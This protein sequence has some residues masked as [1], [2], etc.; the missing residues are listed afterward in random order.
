MDR[1]RRWL[2]ASLE[3]CAAVIF[4]AIV[5]ALPFVIAEQAQPNQPLSFALTA[6]GSDAAPAAELEALIAEQLAGWH[7][8]IE[9]SEAAMLLHLQGEPGAGADQEKL[10]EI[11]GASGYT[12][13][14]VEPAADGLLAPERVIWLLLVQSVVFIAGGLG[15][16]SLR[17]RRDRLPPRAEPRAQVAAGVLYG[18]AALLGSIALSILLHLLGFEPQEQPWVVDLARQQGT[19]LVIFLLLAV[20][21]VPVSEEILFRCYAFERVRQA[22]GIAAAYLVSSFLFAAVH[23]NLSALPIYLY[24]GLILAVAYH[25]TGTVVAPA[26][27][28]SINN[29]LAFSMLFVAENGPV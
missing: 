1:L 4:C 6:T 12:I 26:I 14:E 15:L 3:V 10:A 25:R 28:H 7:A 9:E 2:G 17:C 27:A 29:L 20:V 16:R 23:A 21:L 22:G 18:G 24:L 19:E 13:E 5:S 11:A 8:R